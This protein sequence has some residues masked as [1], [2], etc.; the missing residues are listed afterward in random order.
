MCSL[1]DR[2][3]HLLL[4]VLE[5]PP[6]GNE[7]ELQ[8]ELVLEPMLGQWRPA[9]CALP[10]PAAEIPSPQPLFLELHPSQ[11]PAPAAAAFT[12]AVFGQFV[13]DVNEDEIVLSQVVPAAAIVLSD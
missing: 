1:K 2:T 10:A 6:T 3:A 4:S 7:H 13:Y 9:A 8:P 12:P 5:G 11:L